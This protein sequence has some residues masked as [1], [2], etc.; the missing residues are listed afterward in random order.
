MTSGAR[1]F[2]IDLALN[3]AILG[4]A[5]SIVYSIVAWIAAA[6]RANSYTLDVV[7]MLFGAIADGIVA[8]LGAV[9]WH[10]YATEKR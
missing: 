8:A 2:V 3:G 9:A 1:L 5:A 4:T 10:A 7:G 6:L